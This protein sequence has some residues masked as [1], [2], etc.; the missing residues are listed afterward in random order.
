MTTRQYVLK[1]LLLVFPVLFGVATFVFAMLHLAPGDPAYVIAGTQAS[2]ETIEAIRADLGLN[3]PI[4]VQ[5]GRYLL[6]LVNLDLGQSYTL[7]EGQPV[8][9]ILADRIPITIELAV[10]AQLFGIVFGIPLGV[11]SAVKQDRIADHLSRLGALSGISV[12]VF[13]SGPLLILLFTTYL[14]ILPSSGRIGSEYDIVRIT[15]FIVVDTLISGDMAA[16]RSAVTHMLMPALAIGIYAQ[17]WISRFMRSSLL[18][19][20]RK[21]YVR[22]ARAKGQGRKLTLMKHAFRN[23]LIPVVTIVGLQFG[24]M[25]GGAVLTEKVFGIPGIGTLLVNAIQVNDYPVV[26]GA[27]LVFALMFTLVNI[28]VDILYSYLDPRIQQ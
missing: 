2:Q 24:I 27:I 15:G 5:Y 14:G 21:D 7:Q 19:E 28:G 11:V 3:D 6:D 10:Y 13:W 9:G 23:S 17:G 8:L 26:Q 12:P 1:R 25:L 20:I 4:W 18:E 16:F 22:T